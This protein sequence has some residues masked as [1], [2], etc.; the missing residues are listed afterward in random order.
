MVVLH[1]VKALLDVILSPQLCVRALV[2][3]IDLNCCSG[4]IGASTLTLWW[5]WVFS[6]S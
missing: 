3:Q 6:P 2:A 1:L 4:L 5:D